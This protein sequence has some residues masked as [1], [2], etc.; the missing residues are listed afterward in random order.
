MSK[1]KPA[2][3][4][5]GAPAG[6][7]DDPP[8]IAA[9]KRMLAIEIATQL[10]PLGA[11]LAEE[12]RRLALEKEHLNAAWA[13]LTQTVADKKAEAVRLD[14]ELGEQAA[15]HVA[16]LK[17]L[18]QQVRELLTVNAA[19]QADARVE[20]LTGSRLAMQGF[21]ASERELKADTRDLS[22]VLKEL[23]VGHEGLVRVLRAENDKSA[24]TLRFAFEAQAR[25]LAAVYEDKMARC[26][27]EMNA[28]RDADLAAIEQRKAAHVSA[29]LAAHEQAFTDI[30]AYFNEITHSNLDLIK[31]R[32]ARALGRRRRSAHVSRSRPLFPPTRSR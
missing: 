5:A 6:P 1:P 15:Q 31:V 11:A 22:V 30:K 21:A 17:M 27:E 26:R 29:M 12:T 28:E 16:Q 7:L 18:K 20:A 23:E 2:A 25:E 3:A 13:A 32:F 4:P 24:A 19:G 10:R 9:D 14:T 8:E